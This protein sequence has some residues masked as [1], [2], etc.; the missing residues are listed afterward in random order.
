VRLR[1]ATQ[2]PLQGRDLV[3]VLADVDY[4]DGDPETYTLPLA[5]APGEDGEELVRGNA[6]SVIA[7]IERAGGLPSGVLYDAAVDPAVTDALL[8]AIGSRRRFRAG[9]G[10]ITASPTRQFR[11]LRGREPQLPPTATRTEQTNSSVVLGDRLI[12]KLFRRLEPGINPDLEV[13]RFLADRA[14]RNVPAVA[15]WVAYRV[16]DQEPSALAILQEFVPNKGDL[17]TY[18]LDQLDDFL[19]RAAAV[20]EPPG[21]LDTSV[22]ALLA[23]ASAEAPPIAR[24]MVDTYLDTAWLLGRRTGEL[25]RALASDPDDPAFAP[26]GYAPL[27]QRSLYQSLRNGARQTFQL[28]ERRIGSLPE[29]AQPEIRRILELDDRVEAR[30]RALL[31]ARLVAR[32]IRIHGDYH[33]GQVLWTGRDVVIID[34][35]GEPARPLSERRRKRSALVDVAGMIRSFHYA[36]HGSLIGPDKE[37]AVVRPGDPAVL[38]PW[39]AFWYLNVSAAFLRGYREA[40]GDGVFLPRDEEELARLLDA[41]L[42]EK[43]I[44]ELAYEL[45]N[46]PDWISIPIRGITE[47]L[48]T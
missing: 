6:S 17:W 37:R 12:L 27:D 30:Y 38:E 14:F 46:R 22:R 2:I 35:E 25:H 11:Q 43:A 45:N 16:P 41:F 18:T 23:A 7:R 47:L 4:V 36:A 9:R 29:A 5:F 19:E 24:T 15:G 1:D 40:A 32:R 3:L 28:L 21:R 13:S 8:E 31:D 44:Y 33:A 10:E 48:A 34:F 20:G 39:L 26:E 42:L